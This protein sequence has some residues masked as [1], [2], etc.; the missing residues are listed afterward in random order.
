M[1]SEPTPLRQQLQ[2]MAPSVSGDLA[3]RLAAFAHTLRTIEASGRTQGSPLP[4]LPDTAT[5]HLAALAAEFPGLDLAAAV[6][7]PLPPT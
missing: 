6:R 5:A 7:K 3:S 4:S 1:P 2:A